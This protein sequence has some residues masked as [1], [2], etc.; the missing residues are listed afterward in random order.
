MGRSVPSRRI[1]LPWPGSMTFSI[2]DCR[3][4][5]RA[6]GQR[7]EAALTLQGASIARIARSNYDYCRGGPLQGG[8]SPFGVCFR[9]KADVWPSMAACAGERRHSDLCVPRNP[10]LQE[11]VGRNGCAS[12]PCGLGVWRRGMKG[13]QGLEAVFGGSAYYRDDATGAAYL[14]VWGARHASRFRARLR[15][16]GTY[17]QVHNEA[18]PARLVWSNSRKG[19]RPKVG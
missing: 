9:P 1:N 12:R 16:N 19:R 4:T 6:G 2:F 3:P 5:A 7:A 15:K 10:I 18:P 13:E 17:L 11:R 8:I 14:G